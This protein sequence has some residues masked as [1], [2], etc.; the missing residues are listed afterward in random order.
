M[1]AMSVSPHGIMVGCVEPDTAAQCCLKALKRLGLL[2]H[3]FWNIS[4]L[5]WRNLN[6]N[7]IYIIKDVVDFKKGQYPLYSNL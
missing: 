3:H 6:L 5:I 7:F 4:K 2:N 1:I